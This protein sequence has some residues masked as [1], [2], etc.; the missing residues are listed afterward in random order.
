MSEGPERVG[1][2]KSP[3]AGSLRPFR[4]WRVAPLLRRATVRRVTALSL[5]TAIG[6]PARA[7]SWLN[8][9]WPLRSSPAW[10]ASSSLSPAPLPIRRSS[11]SPLVSLPLKVSRNRLRSTPAWL[12]QMSM[13][14]RSRVRTCPA[15]SWSWP[16]HRSICLGTN[17]TSRNA[18]VSCCLILLVC[19]LS[20]PCMLGTRCSPRVKPVHPRKSRLDLPRVRA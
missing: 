7:S 11:Q 20:M 3:G 17:L 10:V 8:W 19:A 14:T 4:S 15:N 16:D 12:T 6:R 5:S 1:R 18:S 2:W 9:S 13:M